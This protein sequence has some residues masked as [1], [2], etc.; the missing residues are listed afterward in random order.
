MSNGNGGPANR[1]KA[2][3]VK[4]DE[5]G[6]WVK[7]TASP[8]PAGRPSL[9]ESYKE[10][11]AAAGNLTIGELKERYS[12]YA[13]RFPGVPDDI[14]L[15]DLVALSTLVGQAIEPTPGL[16]TTLFDRTDG[17]LEHKINLGKMTDEEI[18]NAVKPILE[19][20][21]IR[22][23]PPHAE[24]MEGDMASGESNTVDA[25]PVSDSAGG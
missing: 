4:R 13:K 25:S 12:I 17:P 14:R 1:K 16:L 18:L 24:G 7:G 22:L 20:L 23:E 2:R 9:G 15:K 5:S 8:N 3:G 10:I 6:K 19:R 21:G 11:L